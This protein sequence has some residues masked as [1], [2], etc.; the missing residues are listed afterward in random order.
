MN[1]R[2]I[3]P[4][5]KII[6]NFLPPRNLLKLQNTINVGEFDWYYMEDINTNA[7]K[8]SL[9]SYFVHVA[10]YQGKASKYIHIFSSIL[11]R[12][13]IKALIRIKVNLYP[14]THA[15]EIH[16]PHI[17]E[18]FP[19]TGAIFYLN[20]NDGKTILE[21]GTKIDS[22]ANRV[23]LFDASKKHSSTSTTDNKVRVN[24]N[25]NYVEG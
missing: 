9:A 10:Y 7:P 12:L 15:L 1:K 3:T 19:H 23:L 11:E 17:D 25:I 20:T 4:P 24:I 8:D 5:Y 16:S 22:V 21:D 2:K 18:N 6:D 14:R 13:E